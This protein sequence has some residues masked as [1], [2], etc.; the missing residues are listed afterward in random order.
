LQGGIY[1]SRESASLI[2]Q[3]GSLGLVGA[4]QSSWGPT[5]YSFGSITEPEQQKILALLL[6]RHKL[7]PAAIRWTKAANH[8]ATLVQ[9][10]I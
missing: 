5:L 7:D 6:D 8:G 2:A 10:D 3:L 1:A 9:V 4:G